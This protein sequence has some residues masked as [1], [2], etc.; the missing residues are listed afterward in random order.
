M[1]KKK[2]RG[3]PG[4]SKLPWKKNARQKT[5][6]RET[7]VS[8][9]TE[10]EIQAYKSDMES[11]IQ[12]A[13]NQ[14]DYIQSQGL[15]TFKLEAFQEGDDNKRFDISGINDVGELRAYMTQ[16]RDVLSSIDDNGQ[17]ALIETA[18]IESQVY[19]G[20][21]GNQYQD[22]ITDTEENRFVRTHFN[23]SDVINEEGEVIRK[24]I[25]PNIA[26]EAF[27]AYRRLEEEY[28]ALI[29]RQGQEGVY[30]SENLIIAIYDYYARGM[31]GQMYGKELLDAWS[32]EYLRELEGINFSLDEASGIIGRWD[33]YLNRRAF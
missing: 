7:P 31:D 11:L 32:D 15:R 5:L 6:R 18:A 9:L 10:E 29:G 24:A 25:D 16:V 3:S 30:G 8:R 19:R 13:N 17:R 14:I 26:K 33:D 23:M 21:F 12:Y 4:A 22:V 28:A 27:S 20:Q 2:K 1:A